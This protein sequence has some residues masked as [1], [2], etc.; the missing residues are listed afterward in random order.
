MARPKS[1]LKRELGQVRQ[2]KGA[3]GNG[4]LGPGGAG[5][6]G[7]SGGRV[8]FQRHDQSSGNRKHSD[9]GCS[10]GL[11]PS[12]PSLEEGTITPK[13]SVGI[14]GIR[15]GWAQR[16]ETL[17]GKVSGKLHPACVHSFQAGLPMPGGACEGCAKILADVLLRPFC[18]TPVWVEEWPLGCWWVQAGVG[19]WEVWASGCWREDSSHVAAS[20]CQVGTLRA[21]SSPTPPLSSL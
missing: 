2:G 16:G 1:P 19:N 12:Q 15:V 6:R 5:G 21:S 3:Q 4:A 7:G 9:Q 13:S 20:C 18:Q 11:W 10:G 14:S 8:H 17:Q